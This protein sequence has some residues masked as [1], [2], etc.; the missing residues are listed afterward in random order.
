[1][2]ALIF[3]RGHVDFERWNKNFYTWVVVREVPVVLKW[4]CNGV[5]NRQKL[6]GKNVGRRLVDDRVGDEFLLKYEIKFRYKNI[7]KYKNRGA[8]V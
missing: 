3:Q 8:L 2:E 4:V 1:M 5:G 6:G 7:K